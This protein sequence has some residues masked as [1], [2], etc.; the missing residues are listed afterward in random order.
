VQQ[1]HRL[2]GTADRVWI[3]RPRPGGVTNLDRFRVRRRD[4]TGGLIHEYL[5]VA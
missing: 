5:L 2:A 4:R 3:S 1:E